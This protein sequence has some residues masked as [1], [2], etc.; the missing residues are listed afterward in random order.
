MSPHLCGYSHKDKQH[1]CFTESDVYSFIH[2]KNTLLL[3]DVEKSFEPKGLQHCD[4]IVVNK[5]PTRSKSM[6]AFLVEL[7][8]SM[9]GE[10]FSNKVID[11]AKESIAWFRKEFGGTFLNPRNME[12]YYVVV[13]GNEAYNSAGAMLTHLKLSLVSSLKE[14]FVDCYLKPSHSYVQYEY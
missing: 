8:R 3:L 11:K 9:E 12:T 1:I 7:K 5:E 2:E 4:F 6:K 10:E 13:L 14:D